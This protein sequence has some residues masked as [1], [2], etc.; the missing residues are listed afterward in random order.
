MTINNNTMQL[1]S[2]SATIPAST[3]ER[4]SSLDN[5]N[6]GDYETTNVSHISSS[7]EAQTDFEMEIDDHLPLTQ[8]QKEDLIDTQSWANDTETTPAI[9]FTNN[10]SNDI[11][12]IPPEDEQQK[13]LD[14]CNEITLCNRS[15]EA[16][17]NLFLKFRDEPRDFMNNA[18]KNSLDN[19][20]PKRK[21]M[22]LIRNIDPLKHYSSAIRAIKRAINASKN[23]NSED[24]F[25]RLPVIASS[26]LRKIT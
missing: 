17:I 15:P 26:A 7:H 22:T 18:I 10:L 24:I 14:F 11:R 5:T 2:S 21:C 4:V 20:I 1:D 9:L 6:P 19:N 25:S 23:N 13:I 12:L 8:S 3:P 16:I